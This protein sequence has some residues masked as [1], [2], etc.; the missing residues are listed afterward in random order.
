MQFLQVLA[1]LPML[2]LRVTRRLERRV[3]ARLTEAGATSPEGAISLEESSRLWPFV[4]RRLRGGGVLV[5]AGND[6]Y[7]FHAESYR[8]FT[9][10]RRQR[11]LGVVLLLLAGVAWLYLRGEM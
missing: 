9:M 11:A 4:R 6:R 10:R 1:V 7:Y 2:L 8:R 5:A 3:I